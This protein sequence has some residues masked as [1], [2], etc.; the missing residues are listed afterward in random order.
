MNASDATARASAHVQPYMPGFEGEERRRDLSQ[1]FTPA[2]LAQRLWD[3]CPKRRPGERFRVCEPAA[4]KGALAVPA[5]ACGSLPE[6][7][8][9]E[10][11][12][13]NVAQLA[14]AGVSYDIGR[15]VVRPRDF[16]AQT[17]D[18]VGC[19][20]LVLQNPP[21]EGGQDVDFIL[22]AL[23]CAPQTIGL[24]PAAIMYSDGRWEKLWRWVDIQRKAELV[25]RPSFGGEHSP[26]TNFCAL[27]LCM[28]HT[29][30][31]AQEP[32]THTTEWWRRG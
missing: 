30:R 28:R 1:F 16:L 17:P 31:R 24:F 7:V 29:A 14:Q 4:G 13:N 15:L 6:V 10:V 20:D 8:A 22:H 25:D 21:F 27:D 26:K 9:Y 12:H 3:W 18:Q 32:F 23:E 19:F 11:D 5:L 2:W